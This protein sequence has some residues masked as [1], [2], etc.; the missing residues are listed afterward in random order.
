MLQSLCLIDQRPTFSK[1]QIPPETSMIGRTARSGA[2][3]ISITPTSGRIIRE[4][5][6]VEGPV[7]NADRRI[8]RSGERL[9]GAAA[10]WHQ[11][12]ASLVPGAFRIDGT[13]A[14]I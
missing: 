7:P 6:P 1:I 14:I 11:D 8:T 9:F 10:R 12:N 13:V 5:L 3:A 4:G 2:S